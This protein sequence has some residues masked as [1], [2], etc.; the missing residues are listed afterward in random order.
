VS[1]LQRERDE[2]RQARDNALVERDV[3]LQQVCSMQQ[4]AAATVQQ[5]EAAWVVQHW[6][7]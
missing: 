5:F 1:R 7:K 4:A 2:A 6:Y 3:A